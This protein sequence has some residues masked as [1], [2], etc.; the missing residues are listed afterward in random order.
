MTSQVRSNLKGIFEDGDSTS[1]SNFSDMI[2]SFVAIS[3]TTAQTMVSDLQA[4]KFI[5]STEVSSVQVNSVE[6]SASVMNATIVNT[7]LVSASTATINIATIQNLIV[8]AV[9]AAAPIRQGG[10]NAW[11]TALM[12]QNTTV[13]SSASGPTGFGGTNVIRLPAN[14]AII[15]MTLIVQ[16]S[17]S[18]NAGGMRVKVGTSTDDSQFHNFLVSAQGIY[19][20]GGIGNIAQVSA[21]NWNNAGTTATQIHVDVTAQTSATQTDKFLAHLRVSYMP[22]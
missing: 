1:G 14:S 6:V 18:G 9:S 17:A 2:D 12:V 10:S 21:P 11:G 16:T 19:R 8:S 3:D 4:P 13:L 22:R 7:P 20:A 5:A 15:D